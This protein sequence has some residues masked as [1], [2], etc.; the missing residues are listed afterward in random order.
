MMKIIKDAKK[1]IARIAD[2]YGFEGMDRIIFVYITG[3]IVFLIGTI[4][5]GIPHGI[6]CIIKDELN[7]KE[8]E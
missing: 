8:A 1:V 2:Q 7:K 4:L 6:V 5:I 3:P